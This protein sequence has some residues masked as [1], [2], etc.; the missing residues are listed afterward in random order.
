MAHHSLLGGMARPLR[1]QER[2]PGGR[3]R[4]QQA[5][6]TRPQHGGSL[7]FNQAAFGLELG[8]S[9]PAGPA[10]RAPVRPPI[11]APTLNSG[12]GAAWANGLIPR[13]YDPL[14]VLEYSEWSRGGSR[15]PVP[16]A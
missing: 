15:C 1:S 8:L 5:R 2:S 10:S 9:T 11:G 12:I 3:V 4:L 16:P 7:A 13:P 14:P 6:P